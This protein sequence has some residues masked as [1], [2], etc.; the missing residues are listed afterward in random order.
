MIFFLFWG[1]INLSR[2]VAVFAHFA[3]ILC[4]SPSFIFVYISTAHT[5]PYRILNALSSMSFCFS[6][7]SAKYSMIMFFFGSD[8]ISVIFVFS[9]DIRVML[10]LDFFTQSF[11]FS[12]K[13]LHLVN[14]PKF[15]FK[16]LIHIFQ[17]R[18]KKLYLNNTKPQHFD[19]IFNFAKLV[20]QNFISGS[21]SNFSSIL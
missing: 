21:N 9:S 14:N 8:D 15:L 17:K 7:P 6:I 3:H 2:Y 11:D 16:I 5:H 12:S 18:P 20:F 13:Y 4:C 1:I 19:H 10:F